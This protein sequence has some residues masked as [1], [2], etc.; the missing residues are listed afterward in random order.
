M[1]AG[2]EFFLRLEES[3]DTTGQRAVRKHGGAP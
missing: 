1:I 2:R 3:P